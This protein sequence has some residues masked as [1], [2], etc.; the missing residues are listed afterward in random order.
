VNGIRDHAERYLTIRR[1]LGYRLKVEGRMLCQ[2]VGFLEERGH[3]RL[4]VQ[5]ALEWA[6]L[7]DDADPS[8]WAA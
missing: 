5:A 8:W 3:S 1:N 4:T 2:F 7:P 6:V